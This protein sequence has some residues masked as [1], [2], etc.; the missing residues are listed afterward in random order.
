M[1]VNRSAA[2]AGS[3]F[4]LTQDTRLRTIHPSFERACERST[5]GDGT[6]VAMSELAA[7]P[8]VALYLPDVSGDVSD[9]QRG[10][11]FKIVRS[12]GERP[13]LIVAV[14]YDKNR[15]A[16]GSFEGHV[17]QQIEFI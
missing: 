10:C 4:G 17:G 9:V 2:E 6:L 1:G 7:Y 14:D 12:Y 5:T 8:R 16:I 3:G 13:G 15:A 11:K